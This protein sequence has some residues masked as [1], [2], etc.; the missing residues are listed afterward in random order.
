MA[1]KHGNSDPGT[2]SAGVRILKGF[3]KNDNR[4][5][6]YA[7][8]KENIQTQDLLR[9]IDSGLIQVSP[10]DKSGL[11]RSKLSISVVN[12]SGIEGTAGKAA[13]I[14]KDLGYNVA[15]TGNADN[16]NYDGITIKVKKEKNNFLNLLR[17]DLSRDYAITSASSDLPQDSPTD[18]LII[19]GK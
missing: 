14:L 18:T 3:I 4:N 2:K 17:K 7:K 9:K 1:L 5:K 6:F 19:I 10:I 13:A 11:D 15:S 12:G 8:S 16:F